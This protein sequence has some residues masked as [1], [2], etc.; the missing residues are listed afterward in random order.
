MSYSLFP[1]EHDVRMIGPMA[2][3]TAIDTRLM[4]KGI[5]ARGCAAGQSDQAEPEGS[6]QMSDRLETPAIRLVI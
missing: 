5:K 4:D 6:W 2:T 3:V 1:T